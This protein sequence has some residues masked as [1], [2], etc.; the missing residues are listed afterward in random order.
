MWNNRKVPVKLF[1]DVE[2]AMKGIRRNAFWL[3]FDLVNVVATFI[4]LI[5]CSNITNAEW[6]VVILETL[7]K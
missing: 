1:A 2:V 7:M 5:F 6:F 3:E 4:C